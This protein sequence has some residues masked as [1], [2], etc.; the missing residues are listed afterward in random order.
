[1]CFNC[2]ETWDGYGIDYDGP[3]PLD[4]EDEQDILTV[5]E[6]PQ[7]LSAEE[8]EILIEQMVQQNMSPEWMVQNYTVARAFVHAA[9]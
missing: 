3:V 2:Q 6:L 7:L 8:Q 9:Y 5:D 1:M 4:S